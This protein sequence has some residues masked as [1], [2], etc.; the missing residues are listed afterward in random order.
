MS[1]TKVCPGEDQA[2][3]PC[4]EQECAVKYQQ[5]DVSNHTEPKCPILKHIAEISSNKHT[6][7]TKV[8]SSLCEDKSKGCATEVR[9]ND[10]VNGLP[11]VC[12]NCCTVNTQDSLSPKS[13]S[14]TQETSSSAGSPARKTSN[15]SVISS[16]GG[17]EEGERKL[18]LRSL[19]E[20]IGTLLIPVVSIAS[21]L[22]L[23]TILL[24]SQ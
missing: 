2:V 16:S 17:S 24:C 19:I 20:S 8:T 11:K 15:I 10:K 18:D 14:I 4:S 6:T 13:N 5:N 1:G 3:R 7:D 23:S 21:Y 9:L 12:C 22:A